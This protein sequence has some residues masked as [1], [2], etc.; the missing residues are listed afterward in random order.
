MTIIAIIGI[1]GCGKTTQAKMLVD[2][3][4]K[5]GQNAEYIFTVF[6]LKNML[7]RGKYK[8]TTSISPRRMRITQKSD[9]DSYKK[10]L[11]TLKKVIIGVLGYFYALISYLI[12]RYHISRN[13]I[14]VCDRYFYQFIFDIYGNWSRRM[15]E[16]FPK[17]DVTFFLS[18]NLDVF[19]S[20]MTSSSDINVE[21]NYYL[22]V[23]KLFNMLTKKYGFIKIDATLEEEKVSDE[24]F[25]NFS[26]Y[27][28]SMYE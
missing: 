8:D 25:K 12:I 18:G 9:L 28:E 22:E 5:K 6:F 14:I 11:F 21:E 19:Y 2:R 10:S 7:T 23:I 16:I 26:I 3:I 13:R 17:P 15:V 24:I 20:R 27:S 1:D 4:K